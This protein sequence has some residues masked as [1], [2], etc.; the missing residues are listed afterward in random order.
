MKKTNIGNT[1]YIGHITCATNNAMMKEIAGFLEDYEHTLVLVNPK[2]F[3]NY[4]K[5]TID[6]ICA[7]YKRC[8]P[9]EVKMSTGKFCVN[10]FATKGFDDQSVF[11][12]ALHDVLQVITF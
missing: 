10:I 1:Y 3:Y 4:V 6:A 12:M 8:K 11:S 2:E 7:K 9:I 5:G